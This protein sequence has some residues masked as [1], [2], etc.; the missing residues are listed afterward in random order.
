MPA[1]T[2]HAPGGAGGSASSTSTRRPRWAARQALARPI[3]PPPTTRTSGLP[4]CTAIATALL[5][6]AG[7]TRIRFDGRRPAGALSARSRAPVMGPMVAARGG[8]GGRPRSAVLTFAVPRRRGSRRP[9]S[10]PRSR[11]CPV[12]PRER[13]ASARLY[14]VCDARPRAFLEA[15]LRGGADVVQLRDKTLDDDAPGRGRARV[16]RRRR[17][18]RRALRPQRPARTSSPRAARTASTSGRTTARPPPP[19]PSSGP[20]AIVGRSTHAPDQGAAA[21]ADPDVDYLAV[22]PVHATPTKPGRPAAG[23]GLRRLGRRPPRHPLVR[24]RRARRAHD[25]RRGRARRPPDRRRPR[26]H[27]GRRPRARRPRARAR[28]WRP[29]LGQRSR[30]RRPPAG[31]TAAPPAPDGDAMRRGYARGRERDERIRAGLAPLGPRERPLPLKLAVAL[32]AL[33]AISNV[34][35]YLAGWEVRGEE[36]QGPAGVI[37]FAGLLTVIAVGM[38]RRSYVAV[39]GFQALLALDRDLHVPLAAGRVERR[40]RRALRRDHRGRRHA[41]LV[42]HPGDGPDPAAVAA[43][44]GAGRLA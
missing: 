36:D 34:A 24:H 22:G 30:K 27:G 8:R 2:C 28:S 38:W 18:A 4:C 11:L 39:L 16:P 19:A 40:G 44:G 1:A 15:A 5:P 13:I 25:P 33:L 23:P 12:T 3:G 31:A 10:D 9:R 20:R 32:A 14:L 41:V 7:T 21:D 29:P 37:F 17:R 42:P 35:L 6:Y 26:D 43:S